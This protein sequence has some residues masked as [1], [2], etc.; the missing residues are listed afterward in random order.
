MMEFLFET[1][2]NNLREGKSINEV[3]KQIKLNISNRSLDTS[4]IILAFIKYLKSNYS[5][6]NNSAT[7][8]MIEKYLN[9]Q[10]SLQHLSQEIFLKKIV[11][12]QDKRDFH[13]GQFHHN[14]DETFL[15][16][17][18]RVIYEFTRNDLI[19]PKGVCYDF[20]L[21]IAGLSIAKN[22]KRQIYMW[23]SIEKISGENNFILFCVEEDNV[24]AYDP[25]NGIY[26]SLE[27]YDIANVGFK[28][29]KLDNSSILT[30]SIELTGFEQKIIDYDE[31]LKLFSSAKKSDDNELETLK[32]QNYYQ[33][34]SVDK[35]ATFDDIKASFRKLIA[36]YHPDI[37]PNDKHANEKTQLIIEAYECLKS[38]ALREEYNSKIFQ[39][40]PQKPSN[41][42]QTSTNSAKFDEELEKI[43]REFRKKYNV[44]SYKDILELLIRM[45]RQKVRQE[46]GRSDIKYNYYINNINNIINDI[47]KSNYTNKKHY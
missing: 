7:F 45:T 33:R 27:K 21:F 32:N 24:I 6:E 12:D 43:I 36:K 18:F 11:V 47:Y 14:S 19:V 16:E 25:F 20:C 23:N 38:T 13:Q 35:S 31:I 30:E 9:N 26:I 4:N 15:D 29:I 40:E 3:T 44:D 22:D 34:L 28:L 41:N 46:A 17:I 2:I 8:S 37:N 1:I 39:N 5:N 10:I 42:T